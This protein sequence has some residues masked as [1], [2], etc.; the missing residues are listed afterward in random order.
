MKAVVHTLNEVA[1]LIRKKSNEAA[2]NSRSK[3]LPEELESC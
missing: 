1:L 2:L 3:A